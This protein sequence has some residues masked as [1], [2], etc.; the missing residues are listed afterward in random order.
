MLGSKIIIYSDH[1]ALKY[2]FSKKYAKSRLIR[3]ILLLQEFDLEIQDKKGS[4]NVV[5]DH[6]SRLTM[7][8]SKDATP[9]F[10]V[11]LEGLLLSYL[12]PTNMTW[13]LKLPSDQNP[14]MIN[15]KSNGDFNSHNVFSMTQVG[16]KQAF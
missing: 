4:E 5:A 16:Q 2:L 6:S 13:L 7:D 15:H 14:T 10:E 11:I 1:A 12:C 9:I 3:W 8:S